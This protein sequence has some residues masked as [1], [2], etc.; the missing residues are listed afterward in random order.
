[1]PAATATGR[2]G[3]EGEHHDPALDVAHG[4][5]IVGGWKPPHQ[6]AQ[7]RHVL[8]RGE[9]FD[10]VLERAQAIVA[11][12]MVEDEVLAEAR[13]LL[14]IARRLLRGRGVVEREVA[15]GMARGEE[16]LEHPARLARARR[17]PALT[18]PWR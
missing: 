9:P 2:L 12:A 13:G 5:G 18:R 7:A 10:V 6:G 3:V 16:G 14:G 17:G 8:L 1:M 11:L 15:Q 4:G